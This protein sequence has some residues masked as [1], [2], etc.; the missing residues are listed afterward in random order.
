M[1]FMIHG[2]DQKTGREMTVVLEAP[3]ESEA[4]R[5]ALYNDILVSSVA[6][7][8]AGA[9]MPASLPQHRKLV[10]PDAPKL[11]YHPLELPPAQR[12]SVPPSPVATVPL[13][14]DVLTGA[15]WLD[16]V[17]VAA[18][19]GG[20]AA[21]IGGVALIVIALVD[22]VRQHL[23]LPPNK[24]LFMAAAAVLSVLGILCVV[25]GVMVSMTSGLV[26]AVRDVAQNTF[27]LAS[28][29]SVESPASDGPMPVV[30]SPAPAHWMHVTT[31]P[32]VVPAFI[33]AEGL[34]P[35][36]GVPLL[37]TSR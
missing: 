16:R 34:P 36:A 11:S 22:P 19:T 1:R 27:H 10:E 15:R 24:G 2:A 7:F 20:A 9:S 17:G 18:I 26:V 25:S 29:T 35:A 5:R 33:D 31:G 37:S 4:E 23:A 3:D 14:R 6:K 28:R 12:G 21:I 32:L 30:T 8:T 13:Y